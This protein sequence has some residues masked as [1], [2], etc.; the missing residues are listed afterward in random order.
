MKPLTK[1]ERGFLEDSLSGKILSQEGIIAIAKA[2]REGRIEADKSYIAKEWERRMKIQLSEILL[3]NLMDK[4]AR[5]E[6]LS[7]EGIK[8][9]RDYEENDILPLY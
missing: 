7:E 8:I 3:A 2:E 9:L 1:K 4:R 6:E 5:K